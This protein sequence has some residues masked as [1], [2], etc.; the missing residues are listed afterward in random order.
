MDANNQVSS[1]VSKQILSTHEVVKD[2]IETDLNRQGILI[3][4][5]KD[6]SMF[7]KKN[8]FFLKFLSFEMF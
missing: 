4:Q 5:Q 7:K 1:D 8:K 2:Q 3:T 6:V